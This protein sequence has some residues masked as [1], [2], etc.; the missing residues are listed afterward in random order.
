MSDSI[1]WLI[2]IGIGLGTY[3]LR[4]SFIHL[5]GRFSMPEVIQRGLRLVPAAVLAAL[6]AP[7]LVYSDGALAV[8]SDDPR[9]LAGLVAL[10][11][12]W[13]YQHMLLTLASGMAVL[14]L[15]PLLV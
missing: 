13:R 15:A 11:V 4:L 5:H 14:W 1:I 8:T 12:A 9:L 10:L 7:A 3:A 2:I 6:V